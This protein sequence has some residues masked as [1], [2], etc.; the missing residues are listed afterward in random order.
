MAPTKSAQKT[1]SQTNMFSSVTLLIIFER[2]GTID[3]TPQ[4]A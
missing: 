4:N 3:P 2:A 1:Y